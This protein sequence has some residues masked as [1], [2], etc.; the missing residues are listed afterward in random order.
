MSSSGRK[1]F[2]TT[3][4]ISVTCRI[5]NTIITGELNIVTGNPEMNWFHQFSSL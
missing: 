4:W 1:M 5:T 2:L 3:D